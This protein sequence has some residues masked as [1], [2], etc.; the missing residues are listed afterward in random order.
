MTTW[1][2]CLTSECQVRY[3]H[4][5]MI[6][7]YQPVYTSF[8]VIIR[9]SVSFIVHGVS[10]TVLIQHFYKLRYANQNTNQVMDTPRRANL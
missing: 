3:S 2:A 10:S 1:R 4:V 8:V 6:P 5:A 9:I 7:R